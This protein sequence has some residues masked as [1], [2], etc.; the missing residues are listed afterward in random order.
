VSGKKNI[1]VI[2]VEK[3]KRDSDDDLENLEKKVSKDSKKKRP[4]H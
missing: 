2:S 4:K 1:N 3:K